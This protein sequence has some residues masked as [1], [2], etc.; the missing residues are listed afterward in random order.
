MRHA[1]EFPP[2]P[3]SDPRVIIAALVATGQTLAVAES[4]TGGL[5]AATLVDVPGASRAFRGGI[6]AYATDLKG[7]LLGV[8]EYLLAEFGPVDPRVAVAMAIGAAA[9][10]KADWGLSTTGVAGPDPQDGH[11]PGEVYVGLSGPG[12]VGR[13]VRL[14]L[15]G[16]RAEV[17]AACVTAAL[18][19]LAQALGLSP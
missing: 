2:N 11:P 4:L 19:V 10:A 5:L 18:G 13:A 8:P 14:E 7:R 15:R 6:V 3:S 1:A 9:A 12:D 17:R 16:D